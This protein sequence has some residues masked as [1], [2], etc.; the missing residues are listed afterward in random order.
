MAKNLNVPKD[1]VSI[2]IHLHKG[3]SGNYNPHTHILV[4]PRDVNGKKLRLHK[5]NLADFHRNWD[6]LLN[7]LGYS[8]QPKSDDAIPHLGEKLFYDEQAQDL[9]KKHLEV[10]RL[11]KKEMRIETLISN[12][13][14]DGRQACL[15]KEGEGDNG[16]EVREMDDRLGFFDKLLSLKGSKFRDKQKRELAKHFQRLG[17][18]PDNKL[19]VVLVNHKDND[20]MQKVYKVRDIL[21]DKMIGFLGFKNAKGYSVYASVNTLRPEAYKRRKENF[22]PEQRRVYLDLDSKKLNAEQMVGKLYRYIR[23]KRLP[24][25]NQIV[26]SS[27]GNYQVYWVLDKP[28][29]YERLEAVMEQMNTDLG[30]DH[31]QDVSRVFRLPYF[32]NRKPGKDDLAMN[33]DDLTVFSGGKGVGSI[34]VSGRKANFEPFKRILEGVKLPAPKPLAVEKGKGDKGEDERVKREIKNFWKGIREEEEIK[35]VKRLIQQGYSE[36][37]ARYKVMLEDKR[38][39]DELRKL[40]L[41]AL[42][43]NKAKSPSE[44]DLS[45][46][47][48]A[49]T[50]YKGDV[51]KGLMDELKNV[52]YYEA[53][54]RNK[55][56]PEAYTERTFNRVKDY[57]YKKNKPKPNPK[58]VKKFKGKEKDLPKNSYPVNNVNFEP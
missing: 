22:N 33:I 6:E 15:E 57:W 34:R 46:I 20:V 45:F 43:R 8:V 7:R 58:E 53:V 38:I 51:P 1:S 35:K 13:K 9:Y 4:Y 48:L 36:K 52:I 55:P 16:L 47:G 19:A 40:A 18:E 32:R 56:N 28:V 37:V 24:M 25:P 49:F 54:N 23:L 41:I 3:I 11:K 5:N 44:V 29:P 21:S 42:D 2:A 12:H 26:K 10:E 17:Y 39:S 27:K 14:G 50:R 30:I 31:T